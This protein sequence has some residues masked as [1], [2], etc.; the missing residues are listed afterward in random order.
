M[1]VRVGGG[2]PRTRSGTD[3]RPPPSPHPRRP[4]S[5]PPPPLPLPAPT[6]PPPRHPRPGRRARTRW[7]GVAPQAPPRGRSSIAPARS[8]SAGATST[9]AH[10]PARRATGERPHASTTMRCSSPHMRNLFKSSCEGNVYTAA[11]HGGENQGA[12]SARWC[13]SPFSLRAKHNTTHCPAHA[14]DLWASREVAT[15]M[16]AQKSAPS[17]DDPARSL[18]GGHA[19]CAPAFMSYA[20][21]GHTAPSRPAA[22]AKQQHCSLSCGPALAC[23]PR[24]AAIETEARMLTRHKSCST[25]VPAAQKVN[26]VNTQWICIFLLRSMPC[27]GAAVRRA[28]ARNRGAKPLRGLAYLPPSAEKRMRRRTVAATFA[29]PFHDLMAA[30]ISSPVRSRLRL[31]MHRC[32]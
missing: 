15:A 30:F 13:P 27:G 8:D 1:D 16:H 22:C 6:S 29:L 31:C 32:S 23:F 14:W 25:L 24:H 28:S 7:R 21:H 18:D 3:L 17:Q 11:P 2:A 9:L 5:S 10:P 26:M 20:L 4:P 12:A 19:V